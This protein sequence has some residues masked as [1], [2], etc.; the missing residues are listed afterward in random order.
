MG[1]GWLEVF[2]GVEEVEMRG[3]LGCRKRDRASSPIKG[4]TAVDLRL[5]SLNSELNVVD[6]LQHRCG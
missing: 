3:L 4:Q 1:D 2:D 5:C 6:T